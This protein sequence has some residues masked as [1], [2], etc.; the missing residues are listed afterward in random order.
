MNAIKTTAIAVFAGV[1]VSCSTNAP[2]PATDL[3]TQFPKT[4]A[5]SGAETAVSGLLAPDGIIVSDSLIYVTEFR[6]DPML[7]LYSRSGKPIAQFLRKGRGPGETSNLLRTSSYNDTIVQVSVDP[8][9]VF[10]YDR[11]DLMQGNLLPYATYQ[12][13]KG[14]YAFSTILKYGKDDFL[15]SGKVSNTTHDCETRFC[16]YHAATDT[17]DTFGEYPTED[18]E[19]DKLPAEDYSRVTAYQGE[20]ILKPD[21]SKAA[22]MY[23][24]AVGFDIVDLEKLAIETSVFYQYPRVE[25]A[26]IPQIKANAIRRNPDTLRGFLDGWCSDEHIYLLYSGKKFSEP[27]YS[28][29]RYILQ[30]D[31]NGKP[32]CCYILDREVGCFASDKA[33]SCIYAGFSDETGG[34][35]LRYGL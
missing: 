14:N 20:P 7:S 18:T 16:V 33:E 11:N 35:I 26:Y 3:L 22:V 34:C 12:L 6:N 24:Y 31:W 17:I 21:H 15:Y 2:K 10:L 5:L 28:V 30:Y 19:I 13:P 4:V 29:G 27:D 1:W 32:I 23:F 9:S 25:A 8:E